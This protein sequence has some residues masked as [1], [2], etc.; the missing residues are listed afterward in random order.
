MNL[1][2]QCLFTPSI[3]CDPLNQP[4]R[5]RDWSDHLLWRVCP[6]CQRLGHLGSP[7][8]LWLQLCSKACF[9]QWTAISSG[10]KFIFL[11]LPIC[12]GW[13][14]AQAKCS[15]STGEDN[16]YKLLA[17]GTEIANKALRTRAWYVRGGA[18]LE[19]WMEGTA[20]RAGKIGWAVM[21]F[22]YQARWV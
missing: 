5:F 13:E 19:S 11:W 6:G 3:C 21:G 14:G 2:L 4:W 22:G 12:G 16:E 17:E 9:F 18:D 10:T 8:C 20:R 1:A 7:K 15:V